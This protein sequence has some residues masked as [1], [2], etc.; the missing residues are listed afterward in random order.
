MLLLDVKRA[1]AEKGIS[2]PATFMKGLGF[3]PWVTGDILEK[4]RVRLDYGQIEK[5]CIG[6]RCT[7]NDLFEWQPSEGTDA[8]HPMQALVRNKPSIPE[9][10]H[11]L[12]PDK[13]E[14]VREMMM[15]LRNEE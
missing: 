1:C 9:L 11:S 8:N 12:T 2:N 4:R 3:N 6:L 10:L 13:I 5:L 15:Q 14:Q 7:P